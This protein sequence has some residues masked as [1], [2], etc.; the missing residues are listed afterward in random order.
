MIAR[1]FGEA[2]YTQAIAY[3]YERCRSTLLPLPQSST[4][5][6]DTPSGQLAV[7]TVVQSS[8]PDVPPF[9]AVVDA[10]DQLKQA[11]KTQDF[12]TTPF[13]YTGPIVNFCNLRHSQRLNLPGAAAGCKM[14]MLLLLPTP[15]SR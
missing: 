4:L 3:I 12:L 2:Q 6:L 9:R 5:M 1:Y 14:N 7:S 11:G 8:L 13:P 10:S 15:C